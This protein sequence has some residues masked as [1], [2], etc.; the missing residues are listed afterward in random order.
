MH[1]WKDTQIWN[2]DFANI[3]IYL[4]TCMLFKP[5]IG[6]AHFQITSGQLPVWAK[7]LVT[8]QSKESNQGKQSLINCFIVY[9]STQMA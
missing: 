3:A 2:E 4:Q 9:K 5:F 8:L 1:M 7:E 6:I